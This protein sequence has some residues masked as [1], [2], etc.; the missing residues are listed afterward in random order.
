[1]F[2]NME[3]VSS[4]TRRLMLLTAQGVY[5]VGLN[6][7]K[8]IGSRLRKWV[9]AELL[10]A[11]ARGEIT[12]GS[13]QPQP[14]AVDKKVEASYLRALAYDRRT[15]TEERTQLMSMLDELKDSLSPVAYQAAVASIFADDR[16][17]LSSGGEG[18]GLVDKGPLERV[19]A[20][21]IEGD[22]FQMADISEW[23]G[24]HPSTTGKMLSKSGLRAQ[25]E[26]QESHCRKQ[27]TQYGNGKQGAVGLWS[28]TVAAA[29]TDWAASQGKCAHPE[30]VPAAV[31]REIAR[32]RN[33]KTPEE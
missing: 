11:V 33:K 30:R 25:Y 5:Q 19:L 28:V 16:R 15:R 20:P 7:R 31:Q 12:V 4:K 13:Q 6:T 24:T 29:L 22:W 8:P 27:L 2:D 17:A 1:M 32:L 23:L 26:G 21:V 3:S 10:P 14:A 9:S 18:T